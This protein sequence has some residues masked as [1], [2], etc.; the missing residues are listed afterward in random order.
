MCAYIFSHLDLIQEKTSSII[1][2]WNKKCWP[3]IKCNTDKHRKDKNF[4]FS[5]L[6]LL[7]FFSFKC[8]TIFVWQFS[9]CPKNLNR[10]TYINVRFIYVT[11]CLVWAIKSFM[12]VNM[13]KYIFNGSHM[14]H[15][16]QEFFF[17]WKMHI[18]TAFNVPNVYNKTSF[19]YIFMSLWYIDAIYNKSSYM[20]SRNTIIKGTYYTPLLH[21]VCCMGMYP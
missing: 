1:S 21:Y 2:I 20:Q 16:V 5:L 9:I 17:F 7:L 11:L 12:Q 4:Q 13:T 18:T 10:S 8:M 6:L 3:Q 19:L 15:K 14:L